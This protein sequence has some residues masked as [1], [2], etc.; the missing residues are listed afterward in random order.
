ML[1]PPRTGVPGGVF[2]V[3][4]TALTNPGVVVLDIRREWFSEFRV[5]GSSS[6]IDTL[7]VNWEHLKNAR[8]I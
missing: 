5:S 4:N 7:L 6:A 2:R 3:L 1:D 8:R